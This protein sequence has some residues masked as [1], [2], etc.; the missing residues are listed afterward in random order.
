MSDQEE[1]GY[2]E[3]GVLRDALP[4]TGMI[5]E[6]E[7]ALQR[8]V[9]A[10]REAMLTVTPVDDIAPALE[11]LELGHHLQHRMY[12]EMRARRSNECHPQLLKVAAPV[13][14]IIQSVQ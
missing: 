2:P 13:F 10:S 1:S 12:V 9:E 4:G 8:R 5:Y 6:Y 11:K 14:R 7:Y 3:I